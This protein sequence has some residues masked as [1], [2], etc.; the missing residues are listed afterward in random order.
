MSSV[1]SI[2][3]HVILLSVVVLF[4]TM[5]YIS[6]SS[7]MQLQGNA[8]VIN[9]AGIVR[10]ASQR[11]VKKELQNDSDIALMQMISSIVNEVISGEGGHELVI[12][13]D[14]RYQEKLEEVRVSWEKLKKEINSRKTTWA[15]ERLFELSEEFFIL[16]NETVSAAEN[17]TQKQVDRLLRIILIINI[18]LTSLLIGW[19]LNYFKFVSFRK[20]AE[21]LGKIAY[22]DA[23]SK[24]ANRTSCDEQIRK[25]QKYPPK[26]DIGVIVFDLNDLKYVNDKSGHINGDKMILEFAKML[27]NA[28]QNSDFVAL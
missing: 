19:L 12:F 16:T 23:V 2:K 5:S 3:N 8:R 1:A 15:N 6:Y 4:I 27:K 18:M 7:I 10:G 13:N 17:Y 14:K 26:D 20:K 22:I 25:Y 9:Y 28:L 24:I 21:D 11:L